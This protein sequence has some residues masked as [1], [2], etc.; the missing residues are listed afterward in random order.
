MFDTLTQRLTTALD[1]LRGRGR[2][3]EAD[4]DQALRRVRM[5]LLEADVALPVAR[6]FIERLRERA[7]GE[8]VLTGLNPG[9]TVIKLV[10]DELVALMGGDAAGLNLAAQPPAVILLAGLQGAGKT[11]TAAKLALHLR[12]RHKK[13]VAL[14]SC[15]VYRPAAM[16]QLER[17]AERVGAEYL[18]PAAGAEP[19]SLAEAAR[20]EARRAFADVLIVDSAGRLH[21]DEAMMAEIQ[22]LHA[23]LEPVETLFVVDCMMGQDA[24]QAAAAFDRVLPLTGV[25]LTK[26]DGD[27]RGGAALSVR[28]VTGKPIKFIGRGETPDA[29]EPFDP[30]RMA[31]RILGMGDVLGL[32]ET[33]QQRIDAGQAE[34]LARKI[35]RGKGFDLADLREQL[36]QMEQLGGLGALLD[37]L[38]TKLRAGTDAARLAEGEKRTRRMIGI[39]DSMTPEERRRPQ[40]LDASR[41]RRIARGAGVE[42]QAVNQLLKQ[43]R[44]MAKMVKRLSGGGV[45]RLMRGLGGM[46]RGR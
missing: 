3:T 1:A 23:R 39:I 14:A 34:R 11:T 31:E 44:E 6:D 41:K 8:A 4:V 15:D 30:K 38:P 9:Q 26:A 46:G 40:I 25:I 32:I 24:L 43:H 27:A 33:A 5:A 13:R 28:V 21:V 22:A 36:R 29:L 7:R 12:E 17:L 42:V 10:R 18:P 35:E 20:A 2:L 45:K 16:E 37:K 19:A